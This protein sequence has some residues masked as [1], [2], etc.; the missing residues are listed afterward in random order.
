MNMMEI[1]FPIIVGLIL[2]EILLGWIQHRPYYRLNDTV[3]GISTGIM[4]LLVGVPTLFGALIVYD[5]IERNYSLFALFSWSPIPWENPITFHTAFPFISLEL[6]PFL[7]WCVVLL[8]VDFMYYWFHRL[9]H[10]V[11]FLWGSHV[12]H[13]SSEQ[14]NLAVSFRGGSFQRVFEYAFYLP[15]AFLGVNWI[16]F[17]FCHRVLKLYQFWVHTAAV[18][19]LGPIEYVMVTPSN[20][21]VH[22]GRNPQYIDKNHGGIFIIWDRMFGSYEPEREKINYGITNQLKSFNPL[23][24]TFHY[25]AELWSQTLATKSWKDKVKVWFARPGWMPADLGSSEIVYSDPGRPNYDPPLPNS[26]KIYGIVQFLVLSACGVLA[27]S[28]AHDS[29]F[30]I[31]RLLILIG[32]TVMGLTV[33][34]GILDNRSWVFPAEMLRLLLV[35]LTAFA[36]HLNGY[37]DV[38]V[39]LALLLYSS[40]SLAWLALLRNSFAGDPSGPSSASPA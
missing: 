23:W 16:M 8:A 29:A 10:E 11:N 28:L 36:I 9:S 24:M 22:H 21:R 37:M 31:F 35:P 20:H 7:Y 13:H 40:I 1:A 32:F 2:L 15:L 4:F 25:Y 14:F 18:P 34:G 38:E 27:Y 3:A 17:L 26:A 6:V 12:T 39:L 30:G 33:V 5:W 19:E